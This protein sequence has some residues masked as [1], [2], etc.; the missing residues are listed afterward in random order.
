MTPSPPDLC[1]GELL[2]DSI[3]YHRYVGI[4]SFRSKF[5]LHNKLLVI[6]LEVNF[7]NTT[8]FYSKL[9]QILII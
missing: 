4:E 5:S 3:K 9:I 1:S 2:W 8:D 6:P 7:E